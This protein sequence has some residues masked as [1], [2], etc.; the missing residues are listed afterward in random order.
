MLTMPGGPEA[1]VVLYFAALH[2]L[3]ARSDNVL[4]ELDVLLAQLEFRLA[5][6]DVLLNFECIGLPLLGVSQRAEQNRYQ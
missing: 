6:T 4:I 1:S 5:E 2:E 3:F